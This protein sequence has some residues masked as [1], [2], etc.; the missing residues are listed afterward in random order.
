MILI[1]IQ[2]YLGAFAIVGSI[3]LVYKFLQWLESILN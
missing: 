3:V 1:I 2:A